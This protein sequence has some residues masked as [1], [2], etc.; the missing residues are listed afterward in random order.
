MRHTKKVLKS[1]FGSSKSGIKFIKKLNKLGKKTPILFIY[2]NEKKK[3]SRDFLHWIEMV[4]GDSKVVSPDEF[5]AKRKEL[6]ESVILIKDLEEFDNEFIKLILKSRKKHL[7]N[8]IISMTERPKQLDFVYDPNLMVAPID[9]FDLNVAREEI[10]KF[11]KK[12]EK[13]KLA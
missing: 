5:R 10:P 2:S 1:T 3:A 8:I 13:A 9:N 4:V 6:K 11:M 12:V 7:K